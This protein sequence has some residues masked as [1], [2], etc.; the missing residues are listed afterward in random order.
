MNTTDPATRPA[1]TTFKLREC[2]LDADTPCLRL[3]AGRNPAYP[4]IACE[5]RDI[6]PYREGLRGRGKGLSQILRHF[7]HCSSGDLVLGHTTILL[8]GVERPHGLLWG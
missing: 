6:F 2:F 5:R 1:H 4:L 8:D 3:L 7:V